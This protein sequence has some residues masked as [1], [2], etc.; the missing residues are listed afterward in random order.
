M[1]AWIPYRDTS[2]YLWSRKAR[3][4]RWWAGIHFNPSRILTGDPLYIA[5]VA[6]IATVLDEVWYQVTSRTDPVDQDWR[7]ARVRRLD[8]AR[9]LDV[10]HTGRVLEALL[11][12]PRKHAKQVYAHFRP[13][14]T[15]ISSITIRT[16]KAGRVGATGPA[17]RS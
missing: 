1:R 5:T 10:G 11:H 13:D 4:G 3:D 12:I 8:L 16:S 17:R 14:T 15:V 9:D 2:L 7:S 6:D